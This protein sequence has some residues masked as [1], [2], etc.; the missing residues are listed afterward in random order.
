MYT[1]KKSENKMRSSQVA[2]CVSDTIGRPPTDVG[3][4]TWRW[5]CGTCVCV[6]HAYPGRQQ[7]ATYTHT[8]T[9]TKGKE[10]LRNHSTQYSHFIRHFAVTTPITLARGRVRGGRSTTIAKPNDVVEGVTPKRRKETRE[11]AE[12]SPQ[13]GNLP[14]KQDRLPGSHAVRRC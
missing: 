9:H 14:Q 8:H 5:A 6:P 7:T 3:P 4:P 2:V 11:M 12:N 1:G 13:M 10:E